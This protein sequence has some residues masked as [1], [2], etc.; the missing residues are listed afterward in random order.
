MYKDTETTYQA[1]DHYFEDIDSTILDLLSNDLPLET[2]YLVPAETRYDL[3]SYKMYED[4]RYW[5]LGFMYNPDSDELPIWP[6]QE[7]LT[8]FIVKSRLPEE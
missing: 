8:E 7:S 5:W 1:P 2:T 3:A 4:D 6:T